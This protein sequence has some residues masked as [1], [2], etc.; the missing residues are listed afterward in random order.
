MVKFHRAR[1]FSNKMI[2]H[3][4]DESSDTFHDLL[5]FE[6]K[7]MMSPYSLTIKNQENYDNNL[8]TTGDAI[9]SF[10]INK[11]A[12]Q[13]KDN[14][15]RD[16]VRL[17]TIRAQ[18]ISKDKGVS[19]KIKLDHMQRNGSEFIDLKLPSISKYV[20]YGVCYPNFS[21]ETIKNKQH[22]NKTK[23]YTCSP[24]KNKYYSFLESLN[25]KFLITIEF[26]YRK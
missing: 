19:N 5:E 10:N 12:M 16:S 14:S 4:K 9:S 7:T 21:N 11:I 13:I 17:N 25:V 18:S 23:K 1:I 24:S 2:E 22:R 26:K 6:D 20:K 8:N 15:Q 3:D